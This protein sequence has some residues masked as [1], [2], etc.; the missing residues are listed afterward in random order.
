MITL[1]RRLRLDAYIVA[2]ILTVMVAT[3]LLV[4]VVRRA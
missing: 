1:L 3:P 4:A 2:I